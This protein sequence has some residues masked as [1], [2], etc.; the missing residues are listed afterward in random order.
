MKCYDVGS[1]FI[2]A[3]Q[4][5]NIPIASLLYLYITNDDPLK[6]NYLEFLKFEQN[7]DGSIGIVNPLKDMLISPIQSEEWVLYNS[8]FVY[9]TL[10]LVNKKFIR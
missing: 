8:L 5:Q 10:P 3:V 1:L 4:E 7:A 2:Y 6:D 9:G